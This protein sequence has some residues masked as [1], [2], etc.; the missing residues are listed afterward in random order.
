MQKVLVTIAIIAYTL[1]G[2]I[3]LVSIGVAY[4]NDISFT[5]IIP[6]LAACISIAF[7]GVLIHALAEIQ[8][9]LENISNQLTWLMPDDYTKGESNQGGT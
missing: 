2:G 6:I 7:F 9:H 4:F 3:L 1:A 5:G 8:R